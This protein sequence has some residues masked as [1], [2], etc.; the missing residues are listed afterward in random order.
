[1]TE[2]IYATSN[3]GRKRRNMQNVFAGYNHN[4]VIDES[5]FYEMKNMTSDYYPV[6]S[7]R[8]KRGIIDQFTNPQGLFGGDKLAWVDNGLFYYDGNPICEVN[9]KEKQFVRIGALLCIFPDKLI[10][11]TYTGE[12]DSMEVT[13]HT[14]GETTYNLCKLDGTAYEQYVGDEV[15]DPE[16][17]P[18]WLDTST[19]T[20]V[21][22]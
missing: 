21:L 10:F 3:S 6:M 1:M 8:D 14:T 20:N 4:L 16:K 11:N 2:L 19:T 9:E 12:L 18:V 22:K 5:Q 15:P 17:N 7:P 13:V